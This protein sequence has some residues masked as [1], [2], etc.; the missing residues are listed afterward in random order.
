MPSRI[1]LKHQRLADAL[2]QSRISQNAWATRLGLSRAYLSQLIN[3]K[4]LYP[5]KAA[6]RKLMDGTG[7]TFQQLFV[8]ED[9][10]HP[11]DSPRRT[12]RDCLWE[13]E[14]GPLRLRVERRGNSRRGDQKGANRMEAWYY[15]LRQGIRNVLR[16]PAFALLATIIVALG[17]GANTAIFS[18]VNGVLLRPWLYANPHQLVILSTARPQYGWDGMPVPSGA[19]RNLQQGSRT[20]VEL[21]AYRSD[22]FP[23]LGGPEPLQIHSAEVS[24]QLF[25]ML[26][27]APQLGAGFSAF[28]ETPPG[29]VLISHRLWQQSFAADAQIVGKTIRLG[30]DACTVAG[31]L[32]PRFG[33]PDRRTDI[34]RPLPMPSPDWDNWHLRAVGRLAEGFS[35]DDL[36][37]ELQLRTR[38]YVQAGHMEQG[39]AIEAQ[40]LPE[41]VVG[42]LRFS[43]LVL[44]ASVGLVLLIVTA[45]LSNLLLV[46]AGA[47][48]REW[49]VRTALG[50]GRMRVFRQVLSENLAYSLLGGAFSLL[51][52]H[53]T[54]AFFQA[55]SP[56][57]LPRREEIILDVRVLAFALG[58]S[59]L[60]GLVAGLLPAL[61][62]SRL[63]LLQSLRGA[64]RTQTSARSARRLG[65]AFAVA[66]VAVA[67]VV[68][69]GA[70]LVLRSY[71]NLMHTERGFQS[72]GILTLR[73][74]LP[75]ARYPQDSQRVAFFSQL[76]EQVRSIPVVE[77]AG[78]TTGLPTRGVRIIS[79]ITAEGS[80]ASAPSEEVHT[81]GD[82]ITPGY[83][84]TLGIELLEG[85]YF[86][87]GDRQGT[88]A[89][90]IVNDKLARHFWPQGG[91]LG[92]RVRLGKDNP[93]LTVVGVASSVRQYS[94]DADAPLHL[95]R[96]LQQ[97]PVG[98]MHLMVRSGNPSQAVESV[99]ERIWRLDSELPV[100]GL[101]TLDEVVLGSVAQRRYQTH[102]LSGFALLALI[103]A[104]VGLYGVVS[105]SV[106]RRT[107]EFGINRAL[108]AQ[109]H[110]I[111]QSVLSQAVRV[112]ALGLVLGLSAALALSQ[113]L[114]SLL[115]EISPADPL[116]YLAILLLLMSVSLAASLV[117]AR[118]AVSIDPLQALRC[119]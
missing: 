9:E 73:L 32:P 42:G 101:R 51:L 61:Q 109:N 2:R 37:T 44:S 39:W 114:S 89:A 71:Q 21:A 1:R 22:Q 25:S 33:F 67:T 84:E 110:D 62:V 27:V 50:A 72:Q 111:V 69:V 47:R 91:A 86:N 20:L 100:I 80:A 34:W 68:L 15:D 92:K 14:A 97:S 96:P 87:A 77:S 59:L 65:Q 4:R 105:Y 106:S 46:R 57:D 43:L 107:R 58:I 12:D 108:G 16:K 112:T 8:V 28:S 41:S 88:V 118:R 79:S 83:L 18:I 103:L 76:L 102:L 53:W 55:V 24:P 29:A 94:L 104:T 98:S 119:E 36:R 19:L 78:F 31:V 40:S 48:H 85:R 54:I 6:R 74:E 117:P 66:Q 11:Y 30:E 10:S 95:Y 3:G 64:S 56:P 17:V 38:Q 45:N 70:G 75:Q 82:M 113:W 115:F 49:A 116:T 63:D 7:L 90:V 26:G 5:G 93:W 13:V 60:T 52:A 23:L 81:A 99:K 35:V